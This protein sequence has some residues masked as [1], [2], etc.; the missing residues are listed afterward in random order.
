ML[1]STAIF[2]WSLP[3]PPD[4]TSFKWFSP[5]SFC[6]MTVPT[7]QLLTNDTGSTV[8]CATARQSNLTALECYEYASK[9]K[10]LQDTFIVCHAVTDVSLTMMMLPLAYF[11]PFPVCGLFTTLKNYLDV[12]CNVY[13]PLMDVNVK[14]NLN[15]EQARRIEEL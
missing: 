10:Q 3:I 15:Q 9:T 14:C 11:R 6:S 13:R 5:E 2:L 1:P 4:I 12:S 8:L 7:C